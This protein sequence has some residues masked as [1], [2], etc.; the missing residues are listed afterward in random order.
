MKFFRYFTVINFI[1]KDCTNAN[2][3][4]SKKTLSSTF[5]FSKKVVPLKRGRNFLNQAKSLANSLSKLI[6]FL[7]EWFLRVC[8]ILFRKNLKFL[9]HLLMYKIDPKSDCNWF[10]SRIFCAPI[11]DQYL[12]FV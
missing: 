11:I 4:A 2:F 8:N 10:L 9:T 3:E 7:L 6:D 1:F 5:C 12:N